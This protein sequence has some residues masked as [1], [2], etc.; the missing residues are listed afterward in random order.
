MVNADETPVFFDMLA[1]TRV[2]TKGSKSL[3]VKTTGYEKLNNCDA[4]SSG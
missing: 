4:F 3:L 2:D 1:N